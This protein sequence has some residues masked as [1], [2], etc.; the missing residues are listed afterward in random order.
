MQPPTA[1]H[2]APAY[3][4]E[5][6]ELRDAGLIVRLRAPPVPEDVLRVALHKRQAQ[7]VQV[8]SECGRW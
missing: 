1:Q 4:R 2:L 8:F 3:A 6:G 5:A 7:Q